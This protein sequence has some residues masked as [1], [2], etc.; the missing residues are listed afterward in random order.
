MLTQVLVLYQFNLFL[1]K[2]LAKDLTHEQLGYRVPTATGGGSSRGNNA[3]W[4]LGHLAIATDLAASIGGQPKLSPE[5]WHKA[6]GPGSNPDQMEALGVGSLACEEL[7]NAIENGHKRVE[8]IVPHIP[9]HVLALPHGVAMLDPTPIKTLGDAL[10]HL[11]TTH[12]C[13]HLGQLSAIRR[14]LGF[15]YML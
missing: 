4:I 15:A 12:E 8:Q 11:M 2:Q 3:R 1:A 10:V 7:I 14:T 9:A 5:L 13:F 6:F